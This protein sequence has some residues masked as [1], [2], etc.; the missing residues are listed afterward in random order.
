MCRNTRKSEQ[1][2][3][4]KRN[5]K[6]IWQHLLIQRSVIRQILV[7]FSW[8]V[9][10]RDRFSKNPQ[11]SN[12]M[13]IL[14][15]RAE[16]FLAYGEMDWHEEAKSGFFQLCYRASKWTLQS[17]AV[18]FDRA[19]SYVFVGL[20]IRRRFSIDSFNRLVF[21]IETRCVS[22]WVRSS[23]LTITLTYSA[24]PI[25]PSR[26]QITSLEGSGGTVWGCT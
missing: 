23:Y 16:L 9:N 4:L 12:F 22:F 3:F 5:A 15:V 11:V 17:V 10:F 24:D 25:K 1:E 13:K 14:Q 21:L 19:C 2:T 18:P 20:N 6:S 26:L 8:I 7:T